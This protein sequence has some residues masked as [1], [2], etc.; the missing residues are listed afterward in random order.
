MAKYP[1]HLNSIIDFL[2]LLPGVG[3]RSAERYAFDL[4]EWPEKNLQ[5]F[6]EALGQIPQKISFCS[7]CGAMAPVAGCFYCDDSKRS[8]EEI[9]I[10]ASPKDIF[11]I[12]DS[13]TYNGLYHV[14]GGLLSP[15]LGFSSD[16]LDLEPLFLRLKELQTKEIILAFDSTVEG[17]A[18][19][20]YLKKE[21][22]K[23]PVK[24]SRLAFGI[25]VGSSLD[26]IDSS[27]LSRAFAG[28]QGF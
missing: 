3:Q 14:L 2:K 1:P 27:T 4:L 6:A 13:S 7:K 15:S 17:D 18:T 5:K 28:R 26:Y 24:V 20:L 22:S 16:S 11:A 9:C 23:E 12:E 19:T 21:L 10:V 25:P 8:T